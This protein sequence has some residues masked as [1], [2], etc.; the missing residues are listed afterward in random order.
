MLWVFDHVG[1]QRSP[2]HLQRLYVSCRSAQLRCM[3]TG[4]L[5]YSKGLDFKPGRL[6]ALTPNTCLVFDKDAKALVE[7]RVREKIDADG[8]LKVKPLVGLKPRFKLGFLA[9]ESARGQTTTTL[10]SLIPEL[11]F[12]T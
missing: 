10:S 8:V 5:L 7:L 9:L 1:R 11:F 4:E 12:H 6:A 3:K 2:H